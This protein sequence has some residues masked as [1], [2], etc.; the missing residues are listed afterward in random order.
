L[1]FQNPIVKPKVFVV[2][3]R[4]D[5]AKVNVARYIERLDLEAIVLHEQPNDGKTLMAKF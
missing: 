5:A 1:T 4:D 3:G 2:H